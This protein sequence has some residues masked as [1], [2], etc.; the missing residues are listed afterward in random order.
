MKTFFED[1]NVLEILRV[2]VSGLLFLLSFLAYRL[3]NREQ[4]RTGTSRKGILHTIFIFMVVNLLGA[5][6]VAAAGYFSA[7]PPP[8]SDEEKLNAETYLVDFTSYLVDLT[9]WTETTHGPVLVTRTDYVRKVSKTT[10]DYII[11]YF[12]TGASIGCK[13]IRF[14]S[15]PR[16]VGPKQEP[17]RVGTHYDYVLPIGHQPEGHYEMVCSQFTFP[18]GFTNPQK[19]WWES[20]VAYPSKAV[21]VVFRFPANKPAKNML[22]SRKRGDEAARPIEDDFANLL[23]GGQTVQ[24]VG[25]D[26]KANSRVHFEWE[27]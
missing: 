27:W 24:W 12:T 20:R 21:C 11:P 9:Q 14:S 13:P 22:V 25:L 23:D 26:Q 8:A 2:G 3:I 19:E 1:L 16:F 18:S 4:Q 5:I 6:L 15:P 10:D 17:D 7:R